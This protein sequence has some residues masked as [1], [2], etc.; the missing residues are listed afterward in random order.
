M[1]IFEDVFSGDE[2]LSDALDI[3]IEMNNSFIAVTSKMIVPDDGSGV[4]VGNASHFGG[5]GDEEEGGS[6]G[7][8]D[9]VKVNN[10]LENFQLEEYPGS[11]KDIMSIF[12]EKIAM[13]KKRLEGR[14]DRLKEWGPEGAVS[15][16]VKECFAKYDECKFY[17]GKSLGDMDPKEGMFI[18]S[19]WVKDDDTGETFYYFKD[20]LREVK[21]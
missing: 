8:P 19:F 1:K 4:D 18:I 3:R 10:I 7:S 21:V 6:S 16:F 15:K 11:K 17:M 13:V 12:K 14:E 9:V 20:T 5:G 2:V